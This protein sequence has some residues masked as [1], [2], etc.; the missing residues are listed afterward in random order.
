MTLNPER[1]SECGK[2][3]NKTNMLC[4]RRG[5]KGSIGGF[6]VYGKVKGGVKSLTRETSLVVQWLRLHPPNAGCLVLIL[7]QG[8]R[9]PH[10][11]TRNLY[12]AIKI[13]HASRWNK[14]EKLDMS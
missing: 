5:K 8:T 11:A 10:A 2:D 4:H 7:G 14:K 3:K 6:R 12:T 13:L 9:N 1:W